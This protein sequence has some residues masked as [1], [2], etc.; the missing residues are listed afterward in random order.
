M[1]EEYAFA[2][3]QPEAVEKEEQAPPEPGNCRWCGA[4]HEPVD[5]ESADW[6]CV[7]CQRY[8]DAMICPTCGNLGRISLMPAEVVPAPASPAQSPSKKGRK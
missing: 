5:G 7:E 8:Q 6:L 2:E 3:T 1:T 4:Y